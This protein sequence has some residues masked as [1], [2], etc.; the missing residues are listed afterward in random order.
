MAIPKPDFDKVEVVNK[1]KRKDSRNPSYREWR[2][3]TQSSGELINS[4]KTPESF[5]EFV[6]YCKKGS[7][8]AEIHS[9]SLPLHMRELFQP[10]SRVRRLR[11]RTEQVT[12]DMGRGGR[13]TARTCRGMGRISCS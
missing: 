2:I 10:E 6:Q 9:M 12:R 13:R 8:P 3:L 1:G 5:V 7:T 11:R 4:F